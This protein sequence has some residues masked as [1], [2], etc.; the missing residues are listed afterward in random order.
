MALLIVATLSAKVQ[1]AVIRNVALLSSVRNAVTRAVAPNAVFRCAVLQCV[2]LQCAAIRV[3]RIVALISALI[4][5]PFAA[6]RVVAALP[7]SRVHDVPHVDFRVAD[8]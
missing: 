4:A 5:A 8:P 1:N 3:A 2:V 6:R 7:A